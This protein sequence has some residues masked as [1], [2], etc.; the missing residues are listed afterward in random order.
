MRILTILLIL[1]LLAFPFGDVAK[2]TIGENINIK[3]IDLFSVLISFWLL[4]LILF[5]K[6]DVKIQSYYL[7]FPIIGALSLAFNSVWLKPIEFVVAS[8]YLLRWVSYLGVY[9]VVKNVAS[10][11]KEVIIFML[12]IDGALFVLFGFLQYFFFSSAIPLLNFGWDDH[13]YRLFSV[14]IDPNFAGGFLSLYL[15]FLMG[16][17]YDRTL[18]KNNNNKMTLSLMV[19]FLCSLIALFLTFSRSSLLMFIFG[20][21]LFLILINK[22][23]I[24]LLLVGVVLLYI[25]T[26]SSNFYIENINLF[27]VASSKSRLD[28]YQTALNISIDRPLLG[29]GF[30]TYRYAK[31]LYGIQHGWANKPSHADAGVDNSFLFVLV[32]TGIIGLGAY[33]YFWINVLK[34]TFSQFT[35]KHETQTVVILSSVF[36]LFIHSLFVNSLFFPEIMLWV[37]LQ[38]ALLKE[39]E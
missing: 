35:L 12:I 3:F 16:L 27:R 13:M 23:R 29:V 2:I 28:N 18:R 1:L 14:F 7:L 24:I 6:I 20:V 4:L 8:F 10:K 19:L 30:N 11:L 9:L 31:D 25:L 37:W 33:L 38:L 32:T 34:K 15:I 5:K 36:G 21:T 26:I 22:K 39:K 17:I